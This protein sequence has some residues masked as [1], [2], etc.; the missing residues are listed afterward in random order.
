M[1]SR[2]LFGVLLVVFAL[3]AGI[4][5]RG[6]EGQQAVVSTPQAWQYLTISS[7]DPTLPLGRYG[8]AGWELVSVVESP[9]VTATPSAASLTVFYFKR[10]TNATGAAHGVGR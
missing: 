5:V 6:A 10:P 1:R 3:L 2:Y 4:A 9:A 8:D 7:E